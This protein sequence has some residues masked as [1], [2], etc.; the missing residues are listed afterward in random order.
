MKKEAL[1]DSFS[2][3]LI[4]TPMMLAYENLNFTDK[5]SQIISFNLLSFHQRDLQHCHS[6]ISLHTY[7]GLPVS[8]LLD[9]SLVRETTKTLPQ[10]AL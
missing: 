7:N 10:E 6:R 3:L 9:S 8:A 5:D 1:L 2:P 4:P